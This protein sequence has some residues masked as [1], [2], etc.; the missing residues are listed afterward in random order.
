MRK[1]VVTHWSPKPGLLLR[2]FVPWGHRHTVPQLLVA[3]VCVCWEWP[4][5]AEGTSM[6][7]VT[8]VPPWLSLHP[9][10][11]VCPQEKGPLDDSTGGSESSGGGCLIKARPCRSWGEAEVA[12]RPASQGRLQCGA[13]SF[14]TPLLSPFEDCW[15]PRSPGPQGQGTFS[16]EQAPTEPVCVLCGSATD[17]QPRGR[18]ALSEP[19]AGVC[20]HG[21]QVERSGLGGLSDA[22]FSPL[23]TRS[24]RPLASAS[25][26]PPDYSP[27]A[28]LNLCA[29]GAVPAARCP[30]CPHPTPA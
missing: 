10:T 3:R 29:Q 13:S 1:L 28:R 16:Q 25:P 30:P 26:T 5:R 20:D 6:R 23:F 22:K 14:P 12:P 18:P 8:G 19:A 7:V 24:T 4:A 11:E 15:P 9:H 2:A 17:P 27:R 21:E